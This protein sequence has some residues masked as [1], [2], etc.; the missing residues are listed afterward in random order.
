MIARACAVVLLLTGLSAFAA[1]PCR[2]PLVAEAK[3][4]RVGPI[5]VD[6]M[7]QGQP[8][9]MILDTGAQFTSISRA[10]AQKHGLE[11]HAEKRVRM[12][13]IGGELQVFTVTAH[14]FR[15]G[16]GR[17]AERQM[18]VLDSMR[19]DARPN[20][21]GML[22]EDI[23][24]AF[25]LLVDLQAEKLS[26]YEKTGCAH[27]PPWQEGFS[28]VRIRGERTERIR[29]DVQLDGRTILAELDS[30]AARS[31]LTWHG[32]RALGLSKD[33]P[34]VERGSGNLFGADGKPV[35][36][37]ERRFESIDIGGE[38][39]RF[40]KLRIADLLTDVYSQTYQGA[41]PQFRSEEQSDLLLGADWLRA[42]RVYVARAAGELHFTYLGGPIFEK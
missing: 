30:G 25:D 37:Y 29:F 22:G 41:E 9:P 32:A 10:T 21:H 40:P 18:L 33:S 39:L 27:A 12:Y 5:A 26:L 34:G 17:F 24:G 28:T 23:L 11:I 31:V 20:E 38:L 19:S 14:D 13:G 2:L 6:A 42:H 36:Y 3:I 35:P 4:H 1:D 15:I 16:D 8:I 7:I